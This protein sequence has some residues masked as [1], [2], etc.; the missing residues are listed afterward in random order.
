VQLLVWWSIKKIH[1]A[2][3]HVCRGNVWFLVWRSMIKRFTKNSHCQQP[4]LRR[5]CVVFG[6]AEYYKKIYIPGGHVCRGN[7]SSLV[8]WSI[9]KF[10]EACAVVGLAEY[11]KKNYIT[12]D[13]ACRGNVQ[14]LV[15]QSII[16]KL[17]YWQSHLWRQ[18]AVV[19]LAEYQINC[20]PGSHVCGGNV[21]LLVWQSIIKDFTSP[22]VMFAEAMCSCWSGRVS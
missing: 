9:I 20:I 10:A 8:W 5:Q 18:C 7:V 6:P 1:I 17:H 22:A 2:G 4:C 15:W 12:N 11:H 19:G 16:K 13:H 3:G 21:S 14:S